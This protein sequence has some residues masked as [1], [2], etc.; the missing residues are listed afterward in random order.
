MAEFM[1]C[2]LLCVLLLP[3]YALKVEET[4]HMHHLL[5][6]DN[7]IDDILKADTQPVFRPPE[8]LVFDTTRQR[9]CVL[10]EGSSSCPTIYNI[11]HN[12]MEFISFPFYVPD[13]E[14]TPVSRAFPQ[15]YTQLTACCAPFNPSSKPNNFSTSVIAFAGQVECPSPLQLVSYLPTTEFTRVSSSS[16]P[17][18][19][20]C[21]SS[22]SSAEG[23]NSFSV[24][25]CLSTDEHF[26]CDL[27]PGLVSS[28]NAELYH[29][30][31]SNSHLSFCCQLPLPEDVDPITMEP[32]I[33]ANFILRNVT[34]VF[35]SHLDV[36]ACAEFKRQKQYR[37]EVRMAAISDVIVNEAVQQFSKYRAKNGDWAEL[38]TRYP[39]VNGLSQDYMY[40]ARF[41]RVLDD[42]WTI[43]VRV[44]CKEPV[45]DHPVE[46]KATVDVDSLHRHPT[47]QT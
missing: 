17:G 5:R 4:Q 44:V 6:S 33:T 12:K 43:T 23:I 2:V 7:I 8:S 21:A 10:F 35:N 42:D 15:K 41:R 29:R 18:I 25:F 14:S 38:C 3:M 26:G 27:M 36:H 13:H 24:P 39:S 22:Q 31:G 30:T 20:L 32:N 19:T 37:C 1:L 45:L 34:D 16:V 40:Y 28:R 47:K 11:R 46:R 9:S